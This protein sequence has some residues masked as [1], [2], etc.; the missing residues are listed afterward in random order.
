MTQQRFSQCRDSSASASF[1]RRVSGGFPGFVPF[2]GGQCN[3]RQQ[4][5][6]FR[7]RGQITQ[8]ETNESREGVGASGNVLTIDGASVESTWLH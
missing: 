6:G 7:R 2:A 3:G 5:R 8:I 4:G 1:R